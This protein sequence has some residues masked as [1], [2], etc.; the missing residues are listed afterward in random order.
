M[1]AAPPPDE[2]IDRELFYLSGGLFDASNAVAPPTISP[3]APTPIPP[4]TSTKRSNR[5]P[6]ESHA[7]NREPVSVAVSSMAPIAPVAMTRP[8]ED[9]RSNPPH[10]VGPSSATSPG[11]GRRGVVLGAFAA[12]AVVLVA[13]G[14]LGLVGHASATAP[15][16]APQEH[17]ANTAEV[18]VTTPSATAEP[19]ATEAANAAPSASVNTPAAFSA[20]AAPAGPA[21][22]SS[23][24]IAV[25]NGGVAS[26]ST[27]TPRPEEAPKPTADAPPAEAPTPTLP[28]FDPG[29]ARQALAQGA[30]S[31][32]SCRGP[33]DPSGVARI[34]II[35]APSG[36]VTTARIG[37]P[38]FQGTPAG[39]CIAQK[40]QHLH[41]PAFAGEAVTITKEVTIE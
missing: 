5:R 32:H 27:P 8:P 36:R 2:R 23:N 39:S 11:A 14:K 26:P 3:I 25:N 10:V 34:T 21:P 9:R 20:S 15:A 38:P 6:G 19:T 13:V 1:S 17:R 40:F 18:P 31:A 33:D 28:D 35:F 7:S 24:R 37:G 22:T 41:V 4:P 16:I 29:A 12:A 30:A